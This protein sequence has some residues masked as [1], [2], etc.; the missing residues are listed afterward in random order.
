MPVCWGVWLEGVRRLEG[1]R[2]MLLQG[3]RCVGV[4]ESASCAGEGA[5]RNGASEGVWLTLEVF[6]YPVVGSGCYAQC[7]LRENWRCWFSASD[8]I[9]LAEDLQAL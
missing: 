8:A 9:P 4:A 3:T 7:T 1:V 2:S 6:L 5:E